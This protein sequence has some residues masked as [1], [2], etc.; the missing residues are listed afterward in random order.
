[1]I[2]ILKQIIYSNKLKHNQFISS[3]KNPT[4]TTK[5]RNNSKSDNNNSNNNK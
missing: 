5:D 3:L 2:V 1:M 4:N